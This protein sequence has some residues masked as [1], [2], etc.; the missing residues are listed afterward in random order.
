[1]IADSPPS[2][3]AKPVERLYLMIRPPPEQRAQI[4]ARRAALGLSD[5]Y[6]PA[7]FHVTVWPFGD[8]GGLSAPERVRGLAAIA[9]LDLDVAPFRL[10]L[11]RVA[12]RGLVVGTGARAIAHLRRAIAAALAP[13]GVVRGFTNRPHLSLAYQGVGCA[14][15]PV[16]PIAWTVRELRLVGS[17][18]GQSRH[19]DHGRLSFHPRQGELF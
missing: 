19:R 14:P 17:L 16:A 15:A 4:A 5:A 7:R 13:H 12:E 3:A 6:D 8:I 10:V 18:H 11:D 1:M 9:A 2:D